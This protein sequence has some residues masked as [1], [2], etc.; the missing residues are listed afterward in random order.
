MAE[1]LDPNPPETRLAEAKIAASRI[2]AGR[3][4]FTHPDFTIYQ[5]ARFFI[6]AALEM[7]SV[8][9]GPSISD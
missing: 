3:I 9:V 5:V 4:A 2:P 6:V 1:T 7:Q 8:P